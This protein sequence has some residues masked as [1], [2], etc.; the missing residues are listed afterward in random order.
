MS[1]LGKAYQDGELGVAPDAEKAKTWFD[2][3]TT[4]GAQKTFTVPLQN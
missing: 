3:A 1:R 2:L 4:S